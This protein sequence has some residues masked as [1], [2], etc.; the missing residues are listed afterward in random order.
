MCVEYILGIA[1]HF[2]LDSKVTVLILF[3]LK[4]LGTITTTII[5][6]EGTGEVTF[7]NV[8]KGGGCVGA[9]VAD[10]VHAL[11]GSA[12]SSL[13]VDEDGGAMWRRSL[14][15]QDL[16]GEDNDEFDEYF[17]GMFP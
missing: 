15:A 1:Q 5:S 9:G 4:F 8:S 17:K 6:T 14:A 2:R 12:H 13:L 10:D 11:L 16:A 3:L 7:W